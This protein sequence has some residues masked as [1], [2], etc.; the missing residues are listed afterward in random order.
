MPSKM[1]TS[2]AA[3]WRKEKGLKG[4]WVQLKEIGRANEYDA[5]YTAFD[6]SMKN[7]ME[8]WECIYSRI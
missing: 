6:L 3:F 2:R 7:I 1:A 4:H 8:E 5:P